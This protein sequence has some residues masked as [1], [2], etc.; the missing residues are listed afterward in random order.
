MARTAD[1]P[2]WPDTSLATP[3]QRPPIQRPVEPFQK[4]IGRR[5]AHQA[6]QKSKLRIGRRLH[7]SLTSYKMTCSNVFC[8]G[9]KVTTNMASLGGSF[10]LKHEGKA[11][12]QA[13]RA[14]LPSDGFIIPSK[15]AYYIRLVERP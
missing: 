1:V 8:R 9:L 12:E 15:L 4:I 13:G 2:W 3:F 5:G 14:P 10:L 6:A 11:Y 7:G